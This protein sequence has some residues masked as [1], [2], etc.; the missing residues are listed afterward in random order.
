MAGSSEVSLPDP[1]VEHAEETDETISVAG[2][3]Q[4]ET[5]EVTEHDDHIDG[6]AT[7]GE[8]VLAVVA[9]A[10]PV[11]GGVLGAGAGSDVI[12]AVL[13]EADA[14]GPLALVGVPAAGGSVGAA[15]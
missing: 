15:E 4:G 10:A 7:D 5:T 9:R 2:D 13:L 6:R 1:V 11:A 8:V 14:A 12:G 3:G